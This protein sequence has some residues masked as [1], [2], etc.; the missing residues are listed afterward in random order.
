ML[1]SG[2]IHRGMCPCD[3]CCVNQVIGMRNISGGSVV[4]RTGRVERQKSPEGLDMSDVLVVGG[5][6]QGIVFVPR[7]TGTAADATENGADP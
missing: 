1:P 6:R 4:G 5:G 2:G 7:G 3:G